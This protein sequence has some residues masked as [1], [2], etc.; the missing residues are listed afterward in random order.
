MKNVLSVRSTL[1]HDGDGVVRYTIRAVSDDFAGS[2]MAWGNVEQPTQLAILLSG[3]P[4]AVG[5]SVDYNFGTATTGSCELKFGSI[6]GS[7]HI[8]VWSQLVAPCVSRGGS[9][10]QSADIFFRVEPSGIDQFCSALRGFVP[11]QQN[12]AVLIG[13]GEW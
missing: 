10:F 1:G 5:D 8:G 4:K 3:F 9:R 7:G 11:G 13:V 6:D 2:T 12:E